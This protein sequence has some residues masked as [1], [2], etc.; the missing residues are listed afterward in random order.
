M[1]KFS[2]IIPVYNRP[3]EVVELLDS[4]TMQ[5]IKSHMEV[6]VVEDGSTETCEHEIKH[7]TSQLDIK[8]IYQENTG[9]GMARNKGAQHAKGEYLLF[10]DSDCVIPSDYFNKILAHLEHEDLDCF[11]GPDKAHAFFSPIQKAIS[12]SM[13]SILTTGGIR[14]G[15]HKLD[16]FYPRS[17]NLGV[18]RELFNKIGG[19]SDMR[20]GEDLDFSLKAHQSGMKIG[21]VSDTFVYHKRR[22]SF[23]SFFKQVFNSGAARI[24]LTHRHKGSLKLVHLFP[25]LFVLSIPVAIVLAIFM[26]AW[27]LLP[28]IILPL[29]ILIDALARTKSFKV[30]IIA[31]YASLV[32]SVGY[33]LGFISAL[34]VNTIRKKGRY[35]A[36][37]K[38]FYK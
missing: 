23:K 19:F 12:Y 24:E 34:W 21:L 2:V 37:K 28:Y 1:I 25:A 17:F 13:T 26:S 10:F 32:Q 8:Y 11:G 5:L 30:A 6:I 29:I 22:T 31:T 4:L 7:F 16:K 36:F 38:S 33:G 3:E 15:R 35:E 9:P 18:K 20:F 27:F 14:G